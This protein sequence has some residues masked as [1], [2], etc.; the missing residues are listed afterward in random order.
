MTTDQYQA[1]GAEITSAQKA[2]LDELNIPAGEEITFHMAHLNHLDLTWYWQLPDTIEMCLETIRWHTEMLEEHP[3]ARYS[4]TQVLIL[5][6]VEQIDPELFGRFA[7]MVREGRV[8][9]DS[10][11]V[12]E[13]DHNIPAG[14]SLARQFLYGQSYLQS[15]FGVRAQTIVN[16]DSFGHNRNLP[17]I[18]RLSGI[19]HMIHK[20]PRQK[21]VDLPETP[22]IWRGID[23]TELVMLR[24]INKGAGL[25]SLSQYYELPDGVS[26]LQEKVNRNLATGFHN[27]FGSHCNSDAGGITPYAAPCRGPGY[28]LKYSTPTEFFTAVLADTGTLSIVERPLNYVY[29]GCYTTHIEEKEHCRRAERELR[30]VEFLWTLASLAGH[31]YPR[32]AIAELWWRACYLQFHDI[33]T[34]TGSPESHRDSGA[35]YHELFLGANVLRRKAQILLDRACKKSES[36]KTV[37][38]ANPRACESSGIATVDVQLPI[39]KGKSGLGEIPSAGL[40]EDDDGALTPYQIV[41]RR[42]RQRFIHG[43]MLLAA[44]DIPATGVKVYRLREGEPEPQVLVE[45]NVIENEHLRVEIGGPGI[46]KSILTKTD[47]R[48]WLDGTSAPVRIELWPETDYIGDYGS[49]M[50]AW[51][52]GVTDRHEAAEVA[53]EPEV[54][55]EGPVRATIRTSHRWGQ[56]SFRTEVSLHAGQ[57]WIELRVQIDWHEK[58]TLA[59]LCVEPRLAGE[60]SRT[61]G[62]AFGAETATGDEMEVPAVGWADMSTSDAGF[63]LLNK[64]R[65]GHTFRDN[66]L[67]VS[68]VRCSTGDYDP[69][70]DSGTVQATL[71]LLPHTRTW[72]EAEVARRSDEFSHPLVAWQCE[73]GG[74][75]EECLAPLAVDNAGVVLTCLKSAEARSGYVARLYESTGRSASACMRLGQVLAGC[76]AF[77]SSIIEDELRPLEISDGIIRMSFRPF[78]VKTVLFRTTAPVADVEAGFENSFFGA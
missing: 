20:R 16:S 38:V 33:L 15:R 3:D 73:P 25:P 62:I 41:D 28:H 43:T 75:D 37:I 12:V 52:L 72:R 53:G 17:Q 55:E 2:A 64:D 11:Q 29:Q 70:S 42:V 14:E 59:R 68:L 36:V 13:P 54:V 45:G 57:D 49:E 35:H 21:Y 5:K 26:N 60:M 74:L 77:E 34:G 32:R 61:Y 18:A 7:R 51:C 39:G 23:G 46:I 47:G 4:H 66:A 69:C 1:E 19:R 50:K 9:I 10:G 30:E 67:R 58:E 63:A 44:S 78:E 71:R 56:S 22:Y 48:E 27:L 40:L 24:F 6:I 31:G 76:K 65:P 8:E